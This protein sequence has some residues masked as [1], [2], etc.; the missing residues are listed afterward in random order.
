MSEALASFDASRT[1]T[2]VLSAAG[3][4]E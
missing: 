3:A 4:T 2:T 1:V